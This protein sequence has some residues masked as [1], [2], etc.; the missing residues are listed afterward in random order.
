MSGQ[1]WAIADLAF[2]RVIRPIYRATIS[3]TV[4]NGGVTEMS[5]ATVLNSSYVSPEFV[6]YGVMECGFW[7][8]AIHIL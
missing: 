1:S 4:V 2:K 5:S 8:G 7:G 3:E 6:L